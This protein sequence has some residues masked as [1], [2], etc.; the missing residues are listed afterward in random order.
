MGPRSWPAHGVALLAGLILLMAI[1]LLALAATGSMLL[2]QRMANNFSDSQRANRLAQTALRYGEQA[3]FALGDEQ[4]IAGCTTACFGP[5][6]QALIYANG[7]LPP[8]PEEQT[9]AWWQGWG[10]VASSE[11]SSPTADPATTLFSPDPLYFLIEEIHFQAADGAEGQ[12]IESATDGIGYYRILGRATGMGAG[13][14]AVQEA[15]LARP[16]GTGLLES[17]STLPGSGPCAALSA[18]MDCG[19]L[20]WRKRR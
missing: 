19:R 10:K 14:V 20:S 12:S 11:E 1:S 18:L 17:G 15:I 6:A 4:R 16:W 5:A 2:Q 9:Q 3:L 8:Y 13:S 7:T